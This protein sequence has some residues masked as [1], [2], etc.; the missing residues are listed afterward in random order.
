MKQELSNCKTQYNVTH[1]KFNTQ[2]TRSVHCKFNSF[3]V[4]YNR[5]QHGIYI[6]FEVHWKFILQIHFI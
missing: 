1:S 3:N 4:K 2:I 6:I 5:A